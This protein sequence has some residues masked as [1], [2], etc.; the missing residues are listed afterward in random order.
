MVPSRHRS[1]PPEAAD[2]IAEYRAC[3]HFSLVGVERN[4]VPKDGPAPPPRRPN[5]FPESPG[6]ARKLA[7]EAR[8]RA[9]R[10][11]WGSVG[12]KQHF[13]IRLSQHVAIAGDSE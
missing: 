7:S 11:G 12:R 10:E 5:A 9:G 1:S 4:V 2:G 6:R 8:L 3:A 13:V